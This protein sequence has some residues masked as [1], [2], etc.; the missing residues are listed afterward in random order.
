[1]KKRFF[2]GLAVM[3]A[4]GLLMGCVT[5]KRKNEAS[6]AGKFYHN[7]TAYYNGYWNA[8]EIL[9]ESMIQLRA[10]NQ[11]DYNQIL[12]VED[13]VSVDNPKMVK[14]EMD[15]ILEKVSTV[16]QLHE[17][18]EWVDDCYIMM[19]KAQYLKQEYETAEET[20]E[21][22]QEDFN[23]SNPYGR[24]YK[25][26]KLTGKAAQ[27]ARKEE[28]K[29][30]EKLREEEKKKKEEVK[31]EKAKT[32][33]EIQKEKEKERERAK[34]ERIKRQKEAAENRKKGIKTVPQPTASSSGTSRLDTLNTTQKQTEE[35][36][37]TPPLSAIKPPKPEVDE[38]AYSEGLLWLA[39]TYIKREN[40]FSSE[41][42]LDK[43]QSSAIKK[44]I[45]AELPATFASLYIRQKRFDEA[46]PKLAEAVELTK[47][48][49]LKARYAFI[50]GQISQQ[51]ENY[52]AAQKFFTT[53]KK[54][55]RNPKMEFMAGMASAKTGMLS[56]D[57]SSDAVLAD[58][59]KML[60][61]DKYKNVR[62]QIFFTIAE[63][64]LAQ[65]DKA[66]ALQSLRESIAANTEDTKL[67]AETYYRIAGIHYE[68][69]QYLKASLYYDST[70][71]LLN[72]TDSRYALV[73]KYVSN[74]KDIAANL[75]LIAYQDTLLYFASLSEEDQ[76]KI[77]PPWLKNRKKTTPAE[78][79]PGLLSKQIS[80]RSGTDFGTSSFFAYNKASKDK[81]KE[82]FDKTWGRRNLED[83]WRRSSKASGGEDTENE[84]ANQAAVEKE[85][86]EDKEE[87]QKFLRELPDNPVRQQEANNRIMYA[88]FT[89]GKL[90]RDKIE[91]FSQSASTLEAMHTRFGPTPHELDSYFYLYLDYLDLNK[92]A[93]AEEV[94][95][96]ILRKF[97]DSKYAAILSDPDYFKKTAQSESKGQQYYQKVYDL[98]QQGNHARVIDAVDQSVAVLGE[99][100]GYL[101]KLQL[102]R[103]M[104]LGNQ[105][106]KDAYM[107]ALNELIIA[108]PNTAEQLKAKEILRFLGGDNSAFANV[109]DVDK[110]YQRDENSVHYVAVIT[111]DMDETRHINLKVAI[112]EY[113]KKQYKNERLQLGDASLNVTENAQVILIRK[114][115]NETK[116]M[117]YYRKALRDADEYS[118]GENAPFDILPISQTNYRKMLSERSAAGYR[119]FFENTLLG[120]NSK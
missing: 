98:F 45:R 99:D 69:Q 24:N 3:V 83:N 15:K 29:E 2:S 49:Q 84:Q 14:A 106:G 113:N 112:S 100:I 111:Y 62:D 9:R 22:F 68:D 33:K 5:K 60:R 47:N 58:L 40:W 26:K 74:L 56:G 97:P 48:K 30:K 10:S 67:K 96:R 105:K 38:T 25:S 114:F 31:E 64:Q 46:L 92:A 120:G 91:N 27:K 20:L 115:E 110:L 104:S 6:A 50:A 87:L 88:M 52:S 17:P 34:K 119:Q 102:L 73:S 28:Q 13:F 116:A 94:K 59:N 21:Y 81:G 55:A 8:T 90:F 7:T 95:N 117:E 89:L 12:E 65:N 39:K 86:A 103:A 101:P 75:E 16:A 76:Q 78:P 53:A 18:S 61:E 51:N 79:Q 23:P 63:I 41:M 80:V 19:A 118:G 37:E 35:K 54:Y 72:K 82:E 93:A 57:K 66:S 1:M 70:M 36:V 109:Q 4:I 43:L 44:D 77:I 107:Q 108:H 71:T 42:L 11:D 85:Q 32:R